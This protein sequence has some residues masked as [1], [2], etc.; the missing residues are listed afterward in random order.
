[1]KLSVKL[2]S[3]AAAASVAATAPFALADNDR[4]D[5][6]DDRD[7]LDGIALT[8]TAKLVRFDTD[9][10]ERVKVLGSLKGLSGGDTALVGIDYR[11]ANGALYGVG[12][13]GGVYTV[14]DRNA[15]VTKVGQLSVAMSGGSF[16]VDVNP[17]ADA[18]RIVGDDGQSL[19]FGFATGVTAVDGTLTYPATAAAPATTATGV[20]GAAYTNNDADP[21]TATTLY[22]LDSV[23]DQTVI[24]SP[25]NAGLLAATGTLKVDTGATT[26]WDIYSKVRNGTTVDLEPYATLTTGGRTGVYEI[27]LFTGRADLTGYLPNGIRATAFA[28]P[29][30]QL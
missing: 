16:G 12:D 9:R 11:P 4:D 21:D 13:K 26:G 20:T 6:R 19:R 18:L 14:D 24:Q 22:D 2:A 30:N 23:L 17:A 10:P 15:K 3:L 29:L 7:R 8:D 28:M 5:R 25:A 27:T 1:M